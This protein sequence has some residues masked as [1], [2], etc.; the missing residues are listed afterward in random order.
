MT[1]IFLVRHGQTEWNR[2]ERFRG[3]MDIPLNDAGRQQAAALAKRLAHEPVSAVYTGPLSRA[4]DTAQPIADAF[5]LPC[6]VLKGL[7]DIHY[8]QWAGLTPQEVLERYPHLAALWRSEPHRVQIPDGESLAAVRARA[9]AALQQTIA[10]HPAQTIVL[11]G[12]QVVNKVLLC[13]ILGLDDS[14][15]WRI[16][17]D[18]ACLNLVE[19]H[20]GLFDI[21]CLNDTCHLA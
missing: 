15:F 4:R 14:H 12:H 8:G 16:R 7:L 9:V 18:N 11:V 2:V 1:R 6:Q 21:V 19:Y 20:D 13:A 10:A 3:Q 5:H 17:Q